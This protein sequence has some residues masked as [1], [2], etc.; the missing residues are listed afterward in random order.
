MLAALA[1]SSAG[2]PV[3]RDFRPWAQDAY[4]PFVAGG[5]DTVRL[6]AGFREQIVASRLACSITIV[7]CVPSFAP[8]CARCPFNRL[9]GC[10]H[11][12]HPVAT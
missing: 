12:Q 6:P 3:I 9:A 1:S 2:F 10:T 5:W 8:S 11:A 7:S 4:G